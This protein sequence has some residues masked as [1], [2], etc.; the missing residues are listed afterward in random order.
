M[1]ELA[2]MDKAEKV[3]INERRADWENCCKMFQV[4]P[5][6]TSLQDKVEV[7]GLKEPLFQ[8]QAFGVFWQM[9]QARNAGGGIVA[10]SPGLGK[11]LTFLAMLVAERQLSILWQDVHLNREIESGKHLPYEGQR[12]GDVCPYFSRRPRPGW[13]LCPC[14]NSGPTSKMYVNYGVRLVLVPA[15]LI[16]NWR[17]QWAQHIDHTNTMLDMRVLIASQDPD[18]ERFQLAS[19]ATNINS[20]KATEEERGPDKAKSGQERFL[21]LATAQSYDSWIEK[22]R[23]GGPGTD[24][25]NLTQAGPNSSR[26]VWT[27]GQYK[28]R[29]QFGIACADE[30]HEDVH[31]SEGR[32]SILAR[33]PGN[34]AIWGYSGTPFDHSP[35][36]LQGILTAI[37]RQGVKRDPMSTDTRW[38]SD[39]LYRQFTG[40]VFEKLCNDFTEFAKIKKPSQDALDSIF[41]RLHPF[42][43]TFMIRRT[44]DTQWFGHE[45]VELAPNIHQDISLTH[46]CKWSEA[47]AALEPSLSAE[48]AVRLRSIQ[49]TWDKTPAHQR[50]S[51]RPQALGFRN[52]VNAKYQ[53]RILATCPSLVKFLQKNNPL[54]LKNDEMKQW[55]NNNEKRSPYSRDLREIFEN[56][57][58]LMWLRK[59]LIDLDETR[60]AQGN[61]QKVIILTNF[62]CIGLITKLVSFLPSTKGAQN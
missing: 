13:I 35:R 26:V 20:L 10:D 39:A 14:Q 34:P 31:S 5:T 46:N 6:K 42:L 50:S 19:S 54:T 29:I 44:Q 36:C 41:K 25:E 27:P 43:T 23:R 18:I 52:T 37:E 57:P 49:K 55:R 32:V 60:D 38:S 15:P 40:H 9:I 58:K 48:M 61:E 4:D 16:A 45:L 12:E 8:Y 51:T 21:V 47:I 22:F 24:V 53:L 1:E 7:A 28:Y 62:N 56:S 11:T 17:K 59:F 33:V 30:S 3:E 2:Q